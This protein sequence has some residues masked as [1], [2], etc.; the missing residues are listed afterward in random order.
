MEDRS[1]ALQPPV[2]EVSRAQRRHTRL[3]IERS[4]AVLLVGLLVLGIVMVFW[5]LGTPIAFGAT[6]AIATWPIRNALVGSGMRPGLAGFC[7][8]VISLLVVVLPLSAAIPGTVE[9]VMAWSGT[10]HHAAASMSPQAPDWIAH[11]PLAGDWLAQ[12]WAGM[13]VQDGEVRRMLAPYTGA[14][15]GFFVGFVRSIADSLLQVLLALIIAAMFWT[16]GDALV[17]ETRRA[18][19]RIGGD[20]A[21]GA[22]DVAAR[23]VRGVTYGVVGTALLQGIL[24]AI[25][26]Y[27]IEVPAAGGLAVLVLV[28]AISQ[29]GAPLIPLVWGGAAW[30]LFHQGDSGWGIFMLVWGVLAITGAE[31]VLRPMLISRSGSMPLVLV[32]VGV[33]GG[34][35][36]FG[37]LGLFIGPTLIS[38]GYSL[39]QA[40]THT[41]PVEGIP[42]SSEEQASDLTGHSGRP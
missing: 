10:L 13:V 4:F 21:V 5:P 15:A 32:M 25:G 6:I 27:I 24:A 2:P 35:L 37:F 16:T 42:R 39:L 18:L 38:I 14:I 1:S 26:F 40:W 34:F 20:P 41:A 3:I 8:L 29:I 31:H 28:L 23:A 11:I 7:L 36:S 9:H 17:L 22:L 19:Q 33:F 30:W 12:R